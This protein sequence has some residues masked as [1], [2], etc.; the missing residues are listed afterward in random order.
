MLKILNLETGYGNLKVLKGISLHIKEKEI[1]TIIGANGAGKS[2]LVKTI[3][4]LIKPFKGEIIYK[5]KLLNKFNTEEIVKLGCA[6]VPEGRHIFSTLTVKE[7]LELG[8]YSNYNKADIKRNIEKL[9][10][11]FPILKKREKQ[12]AGTLSGG[13]QQMLA[14]ARALMANPDL[15]LL[16]EPSLGLAPVIVN[17]IFKKI[18]ELNETGLTILLI[19]QNAKKALN[20]A[21]RGYV[22]A[23]GKFIIEGTAED[24]LNNHDVQRAYLGKEYR[25]INE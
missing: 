4:G 5:N 13:E 19:E 3:V 16:D 20:I 24:L 9:N 1:I 8:A 12:L 17:E 18:K 15:L 25:A 14:L 23:T 2:T 6:L 22:L 21:H 10:E 7:N 11:L